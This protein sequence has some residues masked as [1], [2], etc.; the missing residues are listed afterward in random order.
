M[1]QYIKYL[2]EAT[3]QFNR[4]KFP[5]VTEEI[6]AINESVHHIISPFK[7]DIVVSF[8]KDH[9]LKNIWIDACPELTELVISGVLTTGSVEALFDSSRSNPGFRSDLEGYI[10]SQIS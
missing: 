10:R 4:E 5:L 6:Q 2:I 8:L 9:S 7:V 1:K 3:D